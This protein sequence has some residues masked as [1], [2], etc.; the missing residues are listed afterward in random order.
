MDAV[1]EYGLYIQAVGSPHATLL[2]VYIYICA[3]VCA[4]V[5]MMK[6]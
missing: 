5:I 3:C 1:D 4:Y 6:E 2:Q